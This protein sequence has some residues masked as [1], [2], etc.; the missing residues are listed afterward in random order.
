MNEEQRVVQGDRRTFKIIKQIGDEIHRSIGLT[1]DVPS[2]NTDQKVPILDLKCWVE[3]IELNGNRTFLLLHEYYMKQVSSKAVIH[4][5]AALSISSKRTILTQECLRILKNCHEQIG[6]EKIAGHL[7]YF[8]AR[9]QAVGYDKDFRFQVL[10]SAIHAFKVKKEEERTGVTP[11]YRTREWRRNDRRKEKEQKKKTWYKK[12]G[13]ESVLFVA[14]TPNSEMKKMV[15]E[16]VDRSGFKI[17]VVEKAGTRL[18]RAL[19]RNDPFKPETCSDI[20]GC[21]VC[22]GEKKGA[23]RESG[24]TYRIRC[25][26][27]STENTDERCDSVYPGET[28]RNGYTRGNEHSDDLKF[29]REGSVMWKHCVDKHQSVE[30]AFEMEIVDRVRNDPTK[31]QILEAIRIGRTDQDKLMNSRSEWNSN[32]VPRVVVDRS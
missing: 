2:E 28:D 27:H 6:W 5:D 25:L 21:M 19:Q 7:T 18:V 17:K 10:K 1:T 13:R 15:Q 12:G 3:E 31:R 9:M 20:Q 11:F 23:C 22:R 14:A 24:V 30:Q 8:M 26:G 29:R 32:R 4:K 16:T